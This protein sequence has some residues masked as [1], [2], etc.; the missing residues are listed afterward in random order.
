MLTVYFLI[1]ESFADICTSDFF[2]RFRGNYFL[3]GTPGATF[4]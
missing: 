1:L 2:A 4:Q 3:S